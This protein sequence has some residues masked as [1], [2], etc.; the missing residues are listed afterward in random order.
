[1]WLGKR[2]GAVLRFRVIPAITSKVFISVL[3]S[4]IAQLIGESRRI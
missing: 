2:I 1:M 4:N 3:L